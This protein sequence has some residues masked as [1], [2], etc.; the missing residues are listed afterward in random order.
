[1]RKT[2][3]TQSDFDRAMATLQQGLREVVAPIAES[4]E[5]VRLQLAELQLVRGGVIEEMHKLKAH[6]QEIEQLPNI[7][8]QKLQCRKDR[9]ENKL[10]MTKICNQITQTKIE[11]RK[12]EMQRKQLAQPYHDKMNE[13]IQKY[14]K[15]TL[16]Q[17]AL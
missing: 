2:I 14:P 4:I 10:Q 7:R 3:K 11:L 13:L 9:I 5:S 16:P 17:V 6:W 12:L 1:M 15:G 8:E